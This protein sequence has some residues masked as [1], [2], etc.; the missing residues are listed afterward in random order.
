MRRNG[1]WGAFSSKL[2][3]VL[4][5]SKYALNVL[6]VYAQQSA[7]VGLNSAQLTYSPRFPVR[8]KN[9]S[10]HPLLLSGGGCLFFAEP[11]AWGYSSRTP[12]DQSESPTRPSRS[13][14]TPINN[15]N[16]ATAGHNGAAFPSARKGTPARGRSPGQE[17]SETSRRR[18]DV[19]DKKKVRLL[20]FLV[21]PAA[22][23]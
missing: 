5:R 15:P 16:R 13:F 10:Q 12:S 18:Q 6:F 2:A 22:R 1:R 3:R 17:G 8:S 19:M 9:P 4:A 11:P 14:G 21:Q 7:L 23:G 20:E